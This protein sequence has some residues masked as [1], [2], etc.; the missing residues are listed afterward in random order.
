MGASLPGC[1]AAGAALQCYIST[2]GIRTLICN[3]ATLYP[4]QKTLWNPG[5]I[6]EAMP[7]WVAA[8]GSQ[9]TL[10]ELTS[11]FVITMQASRHSS[12]CVQPLIQIYTSSGSW[13][14]L[15]TSYNN[16]TISTQRSSHAATIQSSFPVQMYV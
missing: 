9:C 7:R 10:C 6:N 14:S 13:R 8:G 15:I 11:L 4:G 3:V 1:M 5:A 12:H 16:L 2:P